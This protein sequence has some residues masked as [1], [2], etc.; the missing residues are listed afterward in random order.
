MLM[1]LGKRKSTT[2]I[3]SSSSNCPLRLFNKVNPQK[4]KKKTIAILVYITPFLLS[5]FHNP[6]LANQL[7]AAIPT[8][9]K[10][11]VSNRVAHTGSPKFNN[12]HWSRVKGL[13]SL[14]GNSEEKRCQD[15]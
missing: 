11:Y 14:E 2:R 9:D 3:K 1:A 6:L 15:S 12:L 8:G 13:L 4:R 10:I 5:A 7:A